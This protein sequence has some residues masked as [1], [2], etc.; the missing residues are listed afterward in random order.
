MPKIRTT[1]DL[2]IN[3]SHIVKQFNCY[4]CMNSF[5]AMVGNEASQR[6]TMGSPLFV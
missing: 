1:N 2:E 6:Y 3:V 4:E 5:V